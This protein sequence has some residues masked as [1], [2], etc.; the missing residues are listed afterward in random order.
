MWSTMWERTRRPELQ[1]A[2]RL[3]RL[4]NRE[5]YE[6]RIVSWSAAIHG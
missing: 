6:T 2:E 1:S 4:G 3:G 5:P